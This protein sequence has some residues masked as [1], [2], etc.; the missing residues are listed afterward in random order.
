[1]LRVGVQLP[2]GVIKQLK[3]ANPPFLHGRTVKGAPDLFGRLA[4]GRELRP[5]AA[6][7]LSNCGEAFLTRVK[8]V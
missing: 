8:V 4:G 1:M 2:S 5:P 6:E 3:S 7:R